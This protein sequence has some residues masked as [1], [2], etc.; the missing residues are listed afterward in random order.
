[1]GAVLIM[2]HEKKAYALTDRGT[3]LAL[4][5]SNKIDL[6]ILFE[7]DPVLFNPYG[8]IAV[9]PA[10]HAHVNYVKAMALIGWVTSRAGQKIIRE[11]GRDRFGKPL[12]IPLAIPNP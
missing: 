6:P 12:F 7:G 5:G 4:L 8:I 2:A 10:K 11:F 3:Y 1:M 9:N